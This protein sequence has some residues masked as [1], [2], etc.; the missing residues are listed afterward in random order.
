MSERI[1]EAALRQWEAILGG[2]RGPERGPLS[3]YAQSLLLSELRRLR[4]LIAWAGTPLAA[5]AVC[6]AKVGVEGPT[7]SD[8]EQARAFLSE[9]AAIRAESDGHRAL[10]IGPIL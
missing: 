6:Y 3:A 1:T 2:N 10:D 5:S 8:Y 9:A 7:S 4:G